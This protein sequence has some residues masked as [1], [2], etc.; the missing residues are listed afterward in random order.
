MNLLHKAVGIVFLTAL[1]GFSR[2]DVLVNT[3]G[4]S[5]VGY[6][7]TV[8]WT[9]DSGT[10]MGKVFTVSGDYTLSEIDIALRMDS[11]TDSM[12]VSLQGDN[13]GS[14]GAT[15]ESFTVTNSFGAGVSG[16]YNLAS[17]TNA[18][19]S[20]G[21]YYVT[22]EALNGSTG[23]WNLSNAGGQ[24]Q[25]VVSNDGGN[26]WTTF[27]D[28]NGTVRVIGNPVPEPFSLFTLGAGVAVCLRRKR[29]A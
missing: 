7:P 29:R 27:T 6:F 13:G 16:V 25:L 1:A 17:V 21:T 15:L 24:G 12:L 20:T 8:G 10:Y 28:T 11:E 2:A 14:P 4:S 5:G 22:I 9:L 23:K 26:S 18:A 19:L 3:F